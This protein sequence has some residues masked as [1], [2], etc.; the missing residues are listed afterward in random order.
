M[1]YKIIK[2][3]RDIETN[4]KTN[5]PKLKVGEVGLEI[6]VSGLIDKLKIGNGNL[7]WN[8]LDYF[9][10]MDMSIV[11]DINSRISRIDVEIAD[12][13]DGDA[14]L[15]EKITQEI[16]DRIQSITDVEAR[17][18]GGYT[19]LINTEISNRI[20]GDNSLSILITNLRTDVNN[21][22]ARDDELLDAIRIEAEVRSDADDDLYLV[23]TDSIAASVLVETNYRVHSDNQILR[24]IETLREE[25][26]DKLEI[27]NLLNSAI[28]EASNLGIQNIV[29]TNLLNY[30]NKDDVYELLNNITFDTSEFYNKDD[31][32]ELLNG[33]ALDTSNYYN[34]TEIDD[35]LIDAVNDVSRYYYDKV[36][37]HELLNNAVPDFSNYFNKSDIYKLLNNIRIDTDDFF[38]KTET[39]NLLGSLWSDVVNNYYNREDINELFNGLTAEA[40]SK[41]SVQKV[42]SFTAQDETEFDLPEDIDT[43]N[44]ILV[45]LNGLLQF[46]EKKPYLISENEKIIFDEIPSNEFT[47]TITYYEKT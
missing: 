6:N 43:E 31:I 18:T 23:L 22:I 7:H 1:A 20:S 44:T 29:D 9:T 46:G 32:N 8:D 25:Y 37:I 45:Y 16:S 39:Y 10:A 12:R 40:V 26:Y 14:S 28:I 41:I 5:N 11:D 38:N 17:V 24:R 21:L 42:Y 2:L 35:L 4:W 15:L 3:K 36:E 19:N 13:I 33:I 27:N 34:R 47:V 30:F